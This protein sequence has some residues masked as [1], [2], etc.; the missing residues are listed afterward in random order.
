MTD[1]D[2]IARLERRLERERH[3]RAE[4]EEIA[5]RGMRELWLA[6]RDL[7]ERVRERT[8][9]LERSLLAARQASAA[10]ESFLGELGHGLATPLHAVLGHLELID[11]GALTPADRDRLETARA[12]AD[13]LATL[14]RG[15]V[16]LA[17]ADGAAGRDEIERDDPARW[18]DDLVEAWGRRAAARGQLIVPSCRAHDGQVSAAWHRLRQIVDL[19]LDNAVS[20]GDP[21]PLRVELEVER[22]DEGGRGGTVTCRVVDSGPGLDDVQLGTALEPFVSFGDG[23]GLGIGL[24]RADRLAR[25]ARGSVTLSSSGDATES[26]VMLPATMAPT[27]SSPTDG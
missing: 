17:G 6:N 27:D 18:L 5:E 3:A 15:L 22:T 2:R 24:A 4:A 20:H 7:E 9:D 21:G 19:L 8:A 16:E 14:L 1:D 23:D 26:V 13:Q 25:A 10:K 11:R 12:N